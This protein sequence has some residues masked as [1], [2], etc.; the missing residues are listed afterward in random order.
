[1]NRIFKMLVAAFAMVL[2]VCS[3]VL[4][5]AQGLAGEMKSMHLVLDQVY[6]EMLPLCSNLIGVGR[7]LAGFA[8]LIYIGSRVWKNI[9]QAEA[10]DFY[11]L[12]RPFALGLAILLFPSL[13]ALMNG[14][15]EPTVSATSA[16]V[17]NSDQA[18]AVL[19]KQKENAIKKTDPFKMYV[20]E[21]GNGDSD[22]WYKYAH[23]EDPNRQ[24]EGMLDRLAHGIDFAMAKASYNFRNSIKQWMSE[25]LEVVYAA[26]SL[27]INTIRTFYLLILAILGPLVLA[28]AVFD[29]F[30][31]TLTV[32]IAR[33]VNVFLWLPIA[34]IFGSIIG[35]V[36]ENMLRYDISQ[37]NQQ[38]DTFFSTT[39][40]TYLV[41]LIIGIIGYFS[42]PTVANYVVHAGGGNSIVSKVNSLVVGT[43]STSTRTVTGAGGMVADAL[44]DGARSLK[45]GSKS[46]SN[47][48]FNNKLKSD[49]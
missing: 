17:K 6:K 25:V 33:Y 13:I 37:V 20:G 41:F 31:H 15:L 46:Q 16:M 47:D 43:A 1:M 22:R 42:V 12:M 11:P 10:I 35:K 21:D 8:A 24:D 14:V 26:A 5:F 32:W 18:I 40:T 7:G 34:N 38:G 19:L 4:S 9:A 44:G 23:P 48:Y 29:G 45:G 2:L 30:E 39:D 36:Q 27:C 49:D 28:F 3:P